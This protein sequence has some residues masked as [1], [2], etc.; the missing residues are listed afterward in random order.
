MAFDTASQAVTLIS[1]SA[2]DLRSIL[3]RPPAVGERIVFI[4]DVVTTRQCS[5]CPDQAPLPVDGLQAAV[6]R[7]YGP[8]AG[9]QINAANL[10]SFSSMDLKN[11]LDNSKDKLPQLED[12]LRLAE[13]IV[14]G[15]RKFRPAGLRAWRCAACFL[16]GPT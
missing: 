6:V 12:D 16:N 13:W 10:T 3:P 11:L 14:F 2:A 4:T 5:Q 15:F 9:G 1:P 8:R 7:L